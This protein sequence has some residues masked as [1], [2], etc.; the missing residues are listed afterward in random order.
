RL[1]AQGQLELSGKI[2]DVKGLG[3]IDHQW[4]NYLGAGGWDWFCVQLD[5]DTE[6]VFWHIVNPD[7]SI[8]HRDLTIMF[9]DNSIYHCRRFTLEKM[10]SWISPESG[11]EYGVLW[12]VYEK[13]RGLDLQIRARYSQQEVRMFETLAVQ[14]FTFWEGSMVVSGLQDG[15]EVSGTGFAEFVRLS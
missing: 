4:M 5:N 6:I 8:K 1:Q 11:R 10:E 3:V 9:P 15:K 13:S 7:E 2:F 14:T 12:R